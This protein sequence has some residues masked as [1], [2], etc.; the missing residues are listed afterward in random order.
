M[1]SAILHLRPRGWLPILLGLCAPI[2]FAGCQRKEALAL[3]SV[4]VD[5]VPQ[6]PTRGTVEVLNGSSLTG[7]ASAVAERLR[8]RGFD[9]VKIGNAPDQNHTRTLV[10]ERR[11]GGSTASE[12][13]DA[14]GLRRAYPMR[15][16]NLLVDATVFVGRDIEETLP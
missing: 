3:P 14:L 1:K 10:V 12:V 13:A 11:K 2:L 4:Q 9:V 15:N 16:E 7:A 8:I 5:S 6:I